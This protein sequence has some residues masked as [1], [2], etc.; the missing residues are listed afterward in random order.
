MA[1]GPPP[2]MKIGGRRSRSATGTRPSKLFNFQRSVSHRRRHLAMRTTGF[3]TA[4]RILF[5]RQRTVTRSRVGLIIPHRNQRF[6][7]RSDLTWGK[8][9]VLA[10]KKASDRPCAGQACRPRTPIAVENG[11]VLAVACGSPFLGDAPGASGRN[12][13]K[14][15]A[16]K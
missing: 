1:G 8:H 2:R 11:I 16:H 3:G 15:K 7:A 5:S 12:D 14:R 9:W 10:S 4:P 13:Q 6:T